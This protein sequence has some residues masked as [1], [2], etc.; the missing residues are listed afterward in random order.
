MTY[1]SCKG[2]KC[3]TIFRALELCSSVLVWQEEQYLLEFSTL[4]VFVGA[5]SAVARLRL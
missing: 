4:P 5:E 2:L 1:A 3:H